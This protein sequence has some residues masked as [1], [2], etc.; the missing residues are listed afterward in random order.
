MYA[1]ALSEQWVGGKKNDVVVVIGAPAYP[2]LRWVQ[3]VSWTR[4]EE[5]KIA[6]RD[7]IMDQKTFDGAA[8]LAVIER[9]V[10]AKYKR[11]EMRDFEYLLDSIE[12]PTWV[13]V[14]IFI[15]GIAAAVGLARYFINNDPFGDEARRGFRR[16]W[17]R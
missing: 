9:E 5:L 16:E 12:P 2:A 11:R 8:A 14:M 4:A 15:L 13:L 7:G 10:K 3:V 17:R 1:E 6:I